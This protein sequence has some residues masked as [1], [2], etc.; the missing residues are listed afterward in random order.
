MINPERAIILLEIDQKIL[1]KGSILA[2]NSPEKMYLL[3]SGLVVKQQ[4]KLRVNNLIYAEVFNLSWVEQELGKVKLAINAQKLPQSPQ[5]IQKQA[6]LPS[7]AAPLTGQSEE[8]CAAFL[9]NID[10]LSLDQLEVIAQAIM[11]QKNKKKQ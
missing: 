6:Q 5:P 3:L 10:N 1:D 7:I 9:E 4:G 11:Q 2:D 8:I